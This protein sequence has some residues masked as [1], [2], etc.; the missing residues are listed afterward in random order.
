MGAIKLIRSSFLNATGKILFSSLLLAFVGCGGG[1]GG[2]GP[3]PKPSPKLKSIIITPSNPDIAQGTTIQLTATGVLSNGQSLDLTS[4]VT[5][6]STSTTIVSVSNLSGSKGQAKATGIGTATVSATLGRIVGKTNV[7]GT[8]AVLIAIAVSPTNPKIPTGT[9]L[10][11]T[12]TGVFSD[13]SSQDLTI[14]AS[15]ASSSQSIATVNAGLVSGSSA[16]DAAITASLSG[17]SGSTT[18]M[19][20]SGTLQWISI[21][22]QNPTIAKGTTV[23]LTATGTFSD[24]TMV[25][26]TSSVTWNSASQS[27]A[28]V[29]NVATRKGHVTGVSAGTTKISATLTGVTGSTGLTVTGAT[30]T[31]IQITPPDPSIAAGRSV[32]LN[33]I[34]SFSDGSNQDIT[35]ST[36]W[37]S[38]SSAVATVNAGLVFGIATGSATITAALEGVQGSTTATVT[39]ATLT[40][41]EITPG[42]PTLAQ[43]MTIPLTATGEFSDGSTQNL[44]SA[45]SWVSAATDVAR[46]SNASGT[47]GQLTGISQGNSAITATLNGIT[48]STTATVTTITLTAITVTPFNPEIAN[49]TSLQLTATGTFS[50]GSTADITG[51]VTWLS[52]STSIATVVGGMVTGKSV[53]SA[54]ISAAQGNIS[55]GT[56]VTVAAVTLNSIT[57]T[58]PGPIIARGTTVQLT[59]TGQFSDGSTQDLTSSVTWSSSLVSVATVSN[60][61][62]SHGLVTGV[63]PGTTTI[64]ATLSGISGATP[65]TVT[66]ATLTSLEIFPPALTIASGQKSQLTAIGIFSDGTTLD[67]TSSATWASSNP[68]SVTVSNATGQQGQV[69]GIATGGA[70]ISAVLGSLTATSQVTVSAAVLTSITVTPANPS[71]A[72]GIELQMTATGNYSDGSTRDLTISVTWSSSN[73]AIAEVSN[74]A[75][76]QGLLAAISAGSATITAAMPKTTVSGSTT[77]TV[78]NA[79]LTQIVVQPPSASLPVGIRTRLAAQGVFSDS[80]TLDLTSVV[81]WTTSNSAIAVVSNR[82]GSHGLVTAVATGNA[83][84]TA[85]LNGISGS[86]A[87]TVTNATLVSITVTPVNPPIAA[88]NSVQLTATGTYSDKST[89]DLTSIAS[90]TSSNTGIA[91]VDAGLVTGVSP[92]SATMTAE[93]EGV[94]GT[95][96]V[97]V[98]TATLT[99]IRITPFNPQ[100]ANGTSIQLTATGTFSD[101]STSDITS[102]VMWL[103]SNTSIATVV[104]GLVAGKALAPRPLVPRKETFPTARRSQSLRRP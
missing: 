7:T 94:S 96:G 34:G 76:S 28:A 79:T 81:D 31:S 71:I 6:S 72:K 67:L 42:N 78:T 84:I 53:G 52:S 2:G 37:T 39:A 4:A 26:L 57:V 64:S 60:S 89:V 65:V 3:A 44:T 14:S 93:F 83:T 47:Q 91:V 97:T 82:T 73:T 103:S 55:G 90:W 21:T 33:A 30:L 92:G 50:D 25:D 46:V 87:I 88:G 63:A 40:A 8:S 59:A 38:S 20:T 29:S 99:A 48:G 69:T 17:I 75:G 18:V 56:T 70:T 11:L 36:I 23:I 100:I 9:S 13:G 19:V 32:Q 98:T 101:G 15:W 86:S 1:G 10:Q 66:S 43:G 85:T 35:A 5:W 102:S 49:G 80:S 68:N 51:S 61:S 95:D 104:G 74:A 62:G 77:V 41:I 16:G 58:P 45:V 54:T 24:G 12:A 27:V 22:P